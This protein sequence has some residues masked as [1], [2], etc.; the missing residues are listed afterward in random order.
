MTVSIL[1]SLG[2]N[3]PVC[4][5][6]GGAALS[7]GPRQRQTDR[8][9]DRQTVR[10]SK[11]QCGFIDW[12]CC[13][14]HWVT[15]PLG[16]PDSCYHPQHT[17]Q[18]I[19][20]LVHHTGRQRQDRMS[21]CWAC[22]E[23]IGTYCSP[24]NLPTKRNTLLLCLSHSQNPTS[25]LPQLWTV[26]H[27]RCCFRSRMWC[28]EKKK[29]KRPPLPTNVPLHQLANVFRHCNKNW[30][31]SK[32]TQQR[33]AYTSVPLLHLMLKSPCWFQACVREGKF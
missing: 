30:N 8:Q 15:G 16:H 33:A 12:C 18:K 23:Q 19:S 2:G 14:Q 4:W 11:L 5:L 21:A 25:T 29:K 17:I 27:A 9:T 3:W 32:Q 31:Y 6:V 7:L 26:H 1:H 22:L 28:L 24:G 13:L 10:R 20:T